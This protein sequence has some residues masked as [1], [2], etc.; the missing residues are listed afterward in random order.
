M[1]QGEQTITFKNGV[2]INEATTIAGPME[3]EGPLGK[4]FDK[5][6]SDV[7]CEEKNYELAER[8]LLKESII[9]VLSKTNLT[10]YD[11]YLFV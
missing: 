8:K 1:K 7:Y 11:I 10:K 4:Y 9:K 2:Y 6:F 5:T 3:S